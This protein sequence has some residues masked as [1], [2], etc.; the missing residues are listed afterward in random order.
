MQLGGPIGP[1]GVAVFGHVV[2]P[3]GHRPPRRRGMALT[4]AWSNRPIAAHDGGMMRRNSSHGFDVVRVGSVVMGNS[5]QG[6]CH[7]EHRGHGE[8]ELRLSRRNR[9][10]ECLTTES[11]DIVRAR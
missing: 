6:I 1:A 4:A 10:N 5:K 3:R 11:C 7:R 9:R 8:E 2:G